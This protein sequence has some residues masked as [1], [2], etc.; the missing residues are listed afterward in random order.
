[1]NGSK[2]SASGAGTV[3]ASD[4]FDDADILDDVSARYV[5]VLCK[6]PQTTDFLKTKYEEFRRSNDFR[7]GHS[8]SRYS[9]EDCMKQLEYRELLLFES[10]KWIVTQKALD[11]IA[12]YH[13]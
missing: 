3:S 11:Y 10:E 4:I 8:S 1:M 9:F 6:T 12:K 5:T 7:I 2:S 13:G